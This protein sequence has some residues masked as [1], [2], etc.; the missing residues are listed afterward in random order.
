MSL[1]LENTEIKNYLNIIF[2]NVEI[3]ESLL[4][5]NILINTLNNN[6]LHILNLKF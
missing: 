6:K 3:N 1:Y 2:D 4:L 5:I